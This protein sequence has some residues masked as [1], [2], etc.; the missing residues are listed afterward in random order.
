V[1]RVNGDT[2]VDYDRLEKKDATPILLQAQDPGKW[3]EY[4]EIRVRPLG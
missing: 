3:I 1:V 2:V 4:R